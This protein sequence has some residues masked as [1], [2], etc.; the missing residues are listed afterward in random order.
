VSDSDSF[1]FALPGPSVESDGTLVFVLA[2]FA[3]GNATLRVRLKALKVTGDDLGVGKY[4]EL[5]LVVQPA[6][7]PPRFMLSERID[8]VE[9][10]E[11]QSTA[12][13]VLG[14]IWA[15]SAGSLEEDATQ[16]ISF[17]VTLLPSP[18][19]VTAGNGLM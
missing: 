17:T 12:R 15:I 4:L 14:S 9:A 11:S 16:E 8:L 19:A 6:N 13:L 18:S 5:P 10:G 2:P 1:L 3:S 7:L